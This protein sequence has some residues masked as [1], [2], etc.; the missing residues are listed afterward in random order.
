MDKLE[1]AKEVIRDLSENNYAKLKRSLGVGL[2]LFNLL[3]DNVE[4]SYLDLLKDF[5]RLP[6]EKRIGILKILEV[7]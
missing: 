1:K 7:Q 2:Y 4:N 6:I 3:K 5:D